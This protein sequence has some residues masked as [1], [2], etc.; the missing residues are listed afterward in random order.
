MNIWIDN[1]PLKLNPNAIEVLGRKDY[2]K[3]DLRGASHSTLNNLLNDLIRA[4]LDLPSGVSRRFCKCCDNCMSNYSVHNGTLFSE[5][6]EIEV[7]YSPTE[8]GVVW[9]EEFPDLAFEY[10]D[11]AIW[12]AT[13]WT[14]SGEANSFDTPPTEK[15][16][17]DLLFG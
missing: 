5:G 9:F 4:T 2:Y 8:G 12:K 17:E 16:M 11:G 10:V 7:W 13:I 15:D 6:H 3:L 14:G 1:S